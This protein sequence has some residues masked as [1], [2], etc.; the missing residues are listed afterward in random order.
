MENHSH[1]FALLYSI[2]PNTHNT[3]LD[4]VFIG[5]STPLDSELPDVISHS[6]SSISIFSCAYLMYLK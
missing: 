6:L 2:Y 4:F 1:V 5:L 3:S